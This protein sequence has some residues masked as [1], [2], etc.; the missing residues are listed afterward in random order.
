MSKITV[1]VIPMSEVRENPVAL[2]AVNRESESYIGLRDSIRAVGILN[3]ISV[4]LREENV[5]GENKTFY[6]LIDGLHRYTCALD[7]GLTEIPVQIISLDNAQTLEA[8]I[9]ANIH[10]VETKP[11]LQELRHRSK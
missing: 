7:V 5:D 9:M 3:A 11:E 1:D 2:R 10:K 4:R 6:E 8:Q